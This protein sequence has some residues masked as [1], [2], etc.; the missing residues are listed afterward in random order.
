MKTLNKQASK[1]MNTM[2]A[3]MEATGKDHLEIDNCNKAYMPVH[4]E[5]LYDDEKGAVYSLTHYYKQN[6]DMMRDPDMEFLHANGFWIPITFQMSSPPI[7]EE[8]MWK[9]GGQW[10]LLPRKQAEHASFANSWL[11]NIKQQ[12]GI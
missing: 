12:Q 9:E 11:K 1:V 3:M 10:K 5:K 8:S 7:C 2:V 6:G 4:I